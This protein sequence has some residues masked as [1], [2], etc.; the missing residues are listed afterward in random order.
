MEKLWAVASTLHRTQ[1]DAMIE[2]EAKNE[3]D[4][5]LLLDRSHIEGADRP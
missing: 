4:R 2:R 5:Q 3:L 1:R